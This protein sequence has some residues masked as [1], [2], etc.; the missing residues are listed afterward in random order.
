M[1][2]RAGE[3]SLA[4]ELLLSRWQRDRA[5][6]AWGGR[7]SLAAALGAARRLYR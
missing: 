5:L 7:G 6:D 3:L 2:R 4:L 1:A